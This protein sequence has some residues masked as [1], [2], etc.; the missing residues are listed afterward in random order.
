MDGVGCG[1]IIILMGFHLVVEDIISGSFQREDLKILF[2]V[3]V[4]G[5]WQLLAGVAVKFINFCLEIVFQNNE[6]WKSGDVQMFNN[7]F[8]EVVEVAQLNRRWGTSYLRK[9]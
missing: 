5:G 8:R 6:S 1:D 7:G 3:V 9:K 2:D 4:V